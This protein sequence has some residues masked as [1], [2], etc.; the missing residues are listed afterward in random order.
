MSIAL[1]RLT[2]SALLIS[3]PRG[4]RALLATDAV[5]IKV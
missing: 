4:Y 1:A 3:T 2:P 5:S